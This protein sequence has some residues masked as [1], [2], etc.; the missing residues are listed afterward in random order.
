MVDRCGRPVPVEEMQ[1]LAHQYTWDIIY[2][3]KERTYAN[4]LLKG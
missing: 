2:G 3:K 1:R 4:W